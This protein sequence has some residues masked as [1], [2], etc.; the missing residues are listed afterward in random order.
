MNIEVTDTNDAA[1]ISTVSSRT[2]TEGGTDPVATFTATDADGDAIVWSLS[3]ADAED[4][5]IEGGVLAFKKLAELRESAGDDDGSDNVYEVTL[6]RL[7]W[8]STDVM[9]TVTNVDEMGSVDHRRP[10]AAGRG[11]YG[12]EM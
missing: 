11:V 3:G 12:S 1:V 10:A 4:F 9:V 5:T 2:Y 8:F 7:G 6:E